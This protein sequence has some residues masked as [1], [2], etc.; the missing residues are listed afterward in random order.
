MAKARNAIRGHLT[1]FRMILVS[2]IL[3]ITLYIHL[4][5]L[6]DRSGGL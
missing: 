6:R 2:F 4:G 3:M 5:G 1:S